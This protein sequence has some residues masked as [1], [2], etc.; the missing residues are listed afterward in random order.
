MSPLDA[1]AP[2]LD[3]GSPKNGNGAS[4]VT[5]ARWSYLAVPASLP[6]VRGDVT[7]FA[8]AIGTSKRT[9]EGVRLASTE[10]AANIVEHAYDGAPGPIDVAASLDVDTMTL[11]ISD[12]G[13]GLAFGNEK[14]GLGLGFIW[15][16]WFSDSLSLVA[17]PAGGLEVR[18][19]F[20]LNQP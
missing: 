20:A 19:G 4:S 1:G 17:S 3:A 8:E 10:A 11:V 7:D 16:A 2:W 15:M 14:P 9:L 18:M 6:R 12:H 5:V 13:H